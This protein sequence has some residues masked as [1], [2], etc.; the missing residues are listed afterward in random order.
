MVRDRCNFNAPPARNP[1]VANLIASFPFAWACR[2]QQ[3]AFC[4]FEGAGPSLVA[5]EAACRK[6]LLIQ[7]PHVLCG[8]LVAFGTVADHLD[9]EHEIAADIVVASD[10]KG[11]YHS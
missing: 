7:C 2:Y 6:M 8:E 3:E 11:T 9:A 5:H 10:N 4:R 1:T